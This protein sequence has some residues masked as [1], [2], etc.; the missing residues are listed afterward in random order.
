MHVSV[1]IP[2]MNRAL[3]LQQALRSAIQQILPTWLEMEILVIDNSPDGSA[4]NCCMSFGSKVRYI[5]EP[6]LG[7]SHA[8]NRGIMEAH[9]DFIAFLDDD[10]RA[11]PDWL[12]ALCETLHTTQADAVFGSVE[13]EFECESELVNYARNIY[14]RRIY[15][16]ARTDVSNLYYLLGTVNS[17]F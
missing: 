6:K 3:L 10:E 16:Q 12:A 2:T 4:S 9:G 11:E 17:C 5:H 8:R 15:K 14:R 13:P 1:V 7:I